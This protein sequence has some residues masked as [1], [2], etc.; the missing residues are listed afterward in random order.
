MVITI[1]V[2]NRQIFFVQ[3]APLAW[4][5]GP[6]RGRD[7]SALSDSECE[8]DFATSSAYRP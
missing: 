7:P 6:P 3:R 1:D 2:M 5:E 8:P 4:V